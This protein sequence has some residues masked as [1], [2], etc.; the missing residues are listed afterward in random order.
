MLPHPVSIAATA[1]FQFLAGLSILRCFADANRT[2]G[3]LERLGLAWLVGVS[4]VGLADLSLLAVGAAWGS[5]VVPVLGGGGIL[6]AFALAPPWR[7][8]AGGGKNGRLGLA[9]AIAGFGWFLLAS[10][11]ILAVTFLPAMDY[12][13][14]AVWG[15]R[16][17]AFI[18]DG[19]FSGPAFTDPL[20]I[21]P[22][23]RHPYLLTVIEAL[24]TPAGA[25]VWEGWHR[26][27]HALFFLSYSAVAWGGPVAQASGARRW[28]LAA[29]LVLVPALAVNL[30]VD[31]PREPILGM[32]GFVSVWCLARWQADSRALFL[33]SAL[34]F[35]VVIQQI[36]VDGMPVTA[37]VA[38]AACLIAACSPDRSRRLRQL[39][40]AFVV[41]LLLMLPGWILKN[42][43]P[44]T[45]HSYDV[46]TSLV[47]DPLERLKALPG[48][49]GMLGGE[50]LAR[51]EL[52]GVVPWMVAIALFTG[53]RRRGGRRMRL[54]LLLPGF[55]CVAGIVA[56][57][58]ARQSYL[59]AERNVSFSRR[60]PVFLPALAFA[61]LWIAAPAKEKA[62]QVRVN[63]PPAG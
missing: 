30:T 15:F 8:P 3:R 58:T 1:L 37:G 46:A 55:L 62:G 61:A 36:K 38:T 18:R 6:L 57:Y 53:W 23:A 20:R 27:V 60:I 49:L 25:S 33:A 21:N 29:A 11:V 44:V 17:D 10:W 50:L 39:V 52:Y 31:S 34:L 54:A 26:W 35:A 5:A 4:V 42:R 32:L 22:M 41:A 28:L 13:S 2:I 56:V 63:P 9:A 45:R 19:S 7:G 16:L 40:P 24:Y 43:V 14:F 12:D 47:S 51:P 59:P 48:V